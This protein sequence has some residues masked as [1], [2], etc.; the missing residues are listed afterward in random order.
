MLKQQWV[1]PTKIHTPTTDG[2]LEI[3]VGEGG[4]VKSSGNQA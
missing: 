3:L 2:I 4:E 1:V